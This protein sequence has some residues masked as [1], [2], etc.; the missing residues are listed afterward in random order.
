VVLFFLLFFFWD[1]INL[2]TW[3]NSSSTYF[4]LLSAGIIQACATLPGS[5]HFCFNNYWGLSKTL[6]VLGEV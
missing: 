4:C 2:V 1:R 6:P 5:I 3:W